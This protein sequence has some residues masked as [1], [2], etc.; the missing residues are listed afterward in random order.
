MT[1]LQYPAPVLRLVRDEDPRPLC[2]VCGL[3]HSVRAADESTEVT[4]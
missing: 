3:R 4:A 2:P 1:P